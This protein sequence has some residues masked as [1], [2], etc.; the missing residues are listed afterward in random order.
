MYGVHALHGHPQPSGAHAQTPPRMRIVDNDTGLPD[1]T[2][3]P[4]SPARIRAMLRAHKVRVR[5]FPGVALVDPN[6]NMLLDLLLAHLENRQIYLTSLCLASGL[7]ITNAKRRIEQLIATGL[8][9][10]TDDQADGRRVLISL[11]DS[12]LER[13]S[14]YLD[15]IAA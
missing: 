4:E 3:A 5:M 9:R 2:P 15:R 10:R 12:A 7:P 6:W 11:T 8:L 14:A 13:L 1:D